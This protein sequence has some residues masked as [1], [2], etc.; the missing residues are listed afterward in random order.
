MVTWGKETPC[1]WPRLL[2]TVSRQASGHLMTK[3]IYI[4]GSL[5]QTGAF[6]FLGLSV[7]SACFYKDDSE[8]MLNQ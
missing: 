3:K 5:S 7:K 1:L 6:P 2:C 8:K 4:F